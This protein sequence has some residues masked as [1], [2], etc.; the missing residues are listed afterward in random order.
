M[1]WKWVVVVCCA[2]LPAHA[3]DTHFDPELDLNLKLSSLIRFNFQAKEDRDAGEDNQA[4][5]GPSIQLYLKPLIKLKSVTTFDLND[6]KSRFLVFEGGYRYLITPGE[7]ATNRMILSVTFNFPLKAGF[8]ISDRNR[9]DLDWKK[10]VFNWR[11]RN[12][13]TLE[14]TV[15]IG[16]YHLIPYVAA[17]PYYV[18]QYDKWST[19]DLYV[20]CLL[21]VGKHVQF[22]TYFENEN[23]TGKKTNQP[24]KVVGLAVHFYFSREKS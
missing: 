6:A 12:K 8:R 2:W 23:N 15:A 5:I 9:S 18:S 7:P 11:Y 19:T 3:E 4:S 10:G 16:S 13:F 21:P 20:G 24:V 14:R 17:E 1:C 22:D